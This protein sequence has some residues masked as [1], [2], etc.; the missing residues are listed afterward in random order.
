MLLAG[1]HLPNSSDYPLFLGSAWKCR[2]GG[3]ASTKPLAAQSVKALAAPGN[4]DSWNSTNALDRPHT[5]CEQDYS[6]RT[7]IS[8]EISLLLTV[9]AGVNSPTKPGNLALICGFAYKTQ[10]ESANAFRCLPEA[11]QR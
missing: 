6:V 10:V 3:S 2:F 4:S 1:H 5:L 9:L 7:L 11:N 8:A